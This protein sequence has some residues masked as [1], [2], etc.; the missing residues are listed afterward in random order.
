M[1]KRKACLRGWGF[2]EPRSKM[3]SKTWAWREGTQAE[4]GE[5]RKSLETLL[6]LVIDYFIFLL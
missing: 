1:W 2:V 3:L 6:W 4:E 5:K